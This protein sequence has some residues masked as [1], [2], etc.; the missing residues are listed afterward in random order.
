MS[1]YRFK[2]IQVF[3]I[4]IIDF[5]EIF[6]FSSLNIPYLGSDLSVNTLFEKIANQFVQQRI[7]A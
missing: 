1:D 2:G 3:R 4:C 5:Q 6:R 7:V